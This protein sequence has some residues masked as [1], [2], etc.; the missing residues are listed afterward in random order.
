[1]ENNED[2]KPIPISTFEKQQKLESALFSLQKQHPFYANVLQEIDIGYSGMV[3]TAAIGFNDKTFEFKMYINPEF[4]TKL[5]IGKRKTVLMHEILHFTHG[6]LLRA[7]SEEYKK[8]AQFYNMAMDMA[9]NQYLELFEGLINVKDFKLTDGSP[10]PLFQTFEIYYELLKQ[11]KDANKE[12]LDKYKPFDSHDWE[13]LDEETK[14]KMLESAKDVLKRSIEKTQFG[15][16]DVPDYIK[17]SLLDINTQA[18]NINYKQILKRAI[19]KTVSSQDRKFTW[20]KNSKR[21]GDD[22]PGTTIGDS[23]IISFY[24][25]TSGSMSHT[26]INECLSIQKQFL[27][28][29][30][31][32]CFVGLWNTSLYYYKSW[33]LYKQFKEDD[34]QHGGTDVSEVLEHIKKKQPDLAI[35]MTDGYY[36][37]VDIKNTGSEIIWIITKGGNMDHPLKRLGKT[38]SLDALK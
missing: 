11:H 19:K 38:I 3:P 8:D 5:D 32:K 33:N 4:F 29:G 27:K 30:T 6:H 25:D 23:P 36:E 17:D 35:I 22:A 26:E 24:F 15:F 14:K 9:I 37:D 13:Q 16:S 34:I 31:K 1:M 10:F 12:I 20:K 18:A 21:Y 7:S 28:A 2:N